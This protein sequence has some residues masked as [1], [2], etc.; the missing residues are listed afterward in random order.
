MRIENSTMKM[1]G[2]SIKVWIG[3]QME[4]ISKNIYEFSTK[5][6]L[7]NK[8]KLVTN[9]TS[10]LLNPFTLVI[11][12]TV[13]SNEK[14]QILLQGDYTQKYKESEDGQL[15]LTQDEIFFLISENEK[16]WFKKSATILS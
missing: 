9:P 11:N 10:K 2:S 5:L 7:N 13:N 14:Y 6:V 3:R 15:N 16:M 1:G 8:P 4:R 12:F